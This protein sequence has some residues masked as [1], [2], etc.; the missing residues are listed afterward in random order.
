MDIIIDILNWI[1]G[2][3]PMVMMPLIIIIIG[4]IFRI[5]INVLI[6]SALMVGVGFAGVNMVINWFIGQVSPAVQKMV[7]NRG[8]SASILDGGWPARAAATWAFPLAA[9][10]VFIVI[11]INILML[12]TKRTRTVMVDFWSYNHFIFT[13]ALT[14]YMTGKNVFFAIL[15][16]SIDAIITFKLSDKTTPLVENYFGLEGVN[17]PT[18]NS[19]GWVPIAYILNKLWD[20]IPGINKIEIT[21]E[22]IQEKYGFVGEPLFM[23]SIIGLLIGILA[24]ETVGNV[25]IIALSTSAAMV[26]TPKMMQVLMEGL[27]PFADAVKDILNKKFPDSEFTMGIDAALTVANPSAIATG[28]IM[29]PITLVL[30]TVLPGNKLLPVADIAYQAMWLAAWPAAFSKGNVFRSI[31]STTLITVLV[32]YIATAMGPVHTQLSVAGGFELTEGM[33]MVTTEDAG[34]H[35]VGFVISKIFEFIS[36]LFG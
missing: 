19:V 7:T 21:P 29:V 12:V 33:A 2:L 13:A 23:G 35:F 18:S 34:T 1:A 31:L 30:A 20:I 14:Y 28:I 27:L 16:G 3:G 24:K 36:G 8:I 6:K 25:L 15:A 26:L 11:G 10:M 32:L 17:F 9:V 5:K 22:K 4:L